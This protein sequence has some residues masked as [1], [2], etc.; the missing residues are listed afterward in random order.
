VKPTILLRVAAVLAFLHGVLHTIGGVFGGA[1][2]G[3]QAAALAVMKANRFDAMGA[4]RT[5]WDFY[6]GLGLFVS[7]VFFVEAVV[8]WQL[9]ALARTHGALIRPILAVF[10]VG[11]LASALVTWRYVFLPPTVMQ[12][13]IAGCLAGAFVTAR[14]AAA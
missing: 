10:C 13:I 6:F 5:Y 3:A 11:Y 12:L 7:I 2:P 4:S 1:A 8:F 9:G 14:N